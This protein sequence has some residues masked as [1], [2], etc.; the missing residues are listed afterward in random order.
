MRSYSVRNTVNDSMSKASSKSG[1]SGSST[2]TPQIPKRPQAIGRA[3]TLLSQI[4]TNASL[5]AGHQLTTAAFKALPVDSATPY[6]SQGIEGDESCSLP[7]SCRES[8]DLIVTAIRRAYE[9]RTGGRKQCV[10]EEDIVRY[11]LLH[12]EFRLTIL[13]RFLIRSSLAEAQRA[14]SVYSKLEYG[15]KRLLWLG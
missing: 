12:S 7:T 14:T 2:S 5:A 1:S 13:S 8:V 11:V 4:L 9:I 10:V 3:S 6:V 15:V